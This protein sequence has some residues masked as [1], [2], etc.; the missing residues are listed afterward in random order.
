MT[1]RARSFGRLAEDYD[2]LRPGYPPAAL[3]AVAGDLVVDVGAG[4]GKLTAAVTR[5]GRRVV[6]VEPDPAMRS[7]LADRGLPGVEVVDGTAER[8]P[9]GTGTAS[10]VVYGQ[11]W[12]WADPVA[13]A[14]EARRVLVD[15]G[16]L[17]Q[18][19]NVPDLAV[20]WVRELNRIAG[21]PD[22]A[23][24]VRRSELPGFGAGEVTRVRWEQTLG[25]PDLVRLFSTFSR[26]STR[27]PEDRERMLASI[28][29]S[30]EGRAVVAYPYVCVG[31][32]YRRS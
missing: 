16:V 7:V 32:M 13:A 12:H 28:R 14:A 18:L 25:A 23:P 31:V 6:A 3:A 29:S 15:D 8:V 1:G 4:T 26:V 17:L 27:E 24:E 11:S 20:D 5:S 22:V 10:A 19:W 9:V 30:V 21:L 2:R